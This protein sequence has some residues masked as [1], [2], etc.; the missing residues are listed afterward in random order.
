M[1]NG[2]GLAIKVHCPAV[3][4]A[5]VGTTFVGIAVVGTAVCTL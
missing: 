2:L 5:C 4:I 3:G 1:K